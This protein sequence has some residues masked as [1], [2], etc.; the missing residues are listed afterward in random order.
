MNRRYPSETQDRVMVR[1]PEGMRERLKDSA[2][3][4]QRTMNAEIVARL[5]WSFEQYDG[6][7]AASS[8]LADTIQKATKAGAKNESDLLNRVI[9]LERKVELLQRNI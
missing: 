2:Q 5:I 8:K 1:L 4:T 3:S 6:P 9:E 7:K